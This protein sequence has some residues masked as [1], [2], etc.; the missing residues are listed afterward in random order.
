MK[1]CIAGCGAI[2]SLLAARLASTD[3][4]VT[5]LD[6]GSQLVALRQRGLQLQRAT[7]ASPPSR[8]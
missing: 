3:A 8:G 5:I 6:R 7:G 1:V 2:G 4:D